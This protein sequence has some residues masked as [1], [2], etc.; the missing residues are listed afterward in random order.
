MFSIPIDDYGSKQVK[1][2][3]SQMLIFGCAISD[4]SSAVEV[5]SSFK[6]F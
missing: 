3:H 1:V 6:G 5:E 4:L 2:H